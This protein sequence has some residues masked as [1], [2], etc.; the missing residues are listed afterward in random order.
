MF[1][2]LFGK[3]STGQKQKKDV[4]NIV[5][6]MCKSVTEEGRWKVKVW[7]HVKTFDVHVTETFFKPICAQCQHIVQM[8]DR[9]TGWKMT[10]TSDSPRDNIQYSKL[11]LRSHSRVR[12]DKVV[13]TEMDDLL[14]LYPSS[15][16]VSVNVDNHSEYENIPSAEQL[17]EVYDAWWWA[18][19]GVE[20]QRRYTEKQRQEAEKRQTAIDKLKQMY[21]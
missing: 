7:R 9:E 4:D 17:K 6:A 2:W 5:K 21:L 3:E 12:E 1:K 14:R 18:I 13:I 11:P 8:E 20:T 16:V 15:G 19:V 10:F